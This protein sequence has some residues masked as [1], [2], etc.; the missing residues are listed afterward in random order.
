[1]EDKLMISVLALLMFGKDFDNNFSKA[2]SRITFPLLFHY[3][4]FTQK[5]SKE[6]TK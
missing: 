5:R 4:D 1:M 3:I 6:K 2:K